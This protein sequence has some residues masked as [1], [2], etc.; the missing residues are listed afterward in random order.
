METLPSIW[1]Q[2]YSVT[3]LLMETGQFFSLTVPLMS[4]RND[5]YLNENLCWTVGVPCV[6][7]SYITCFGNR[8]DFCCVCFSK[9]QRSDQTLGACM[10]GVGGVRSCGQ[11]TSPEGKP[12]SLF[13]SPV[14]GTEGQLLTPWRGHLTSL[15]WK[16]ARLE[17]ALWGPPRL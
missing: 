4:W 11:S 7:Y 8:A 15:G 5:F 12:S 1:L 17:P 10:H 14:V 3:W 2:L 16:R 13:Q 9:S 6:L